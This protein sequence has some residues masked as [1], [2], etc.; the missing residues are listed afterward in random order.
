M[1]GSKLRNLEGLEQ[2]IEQEQVIFLWIVRD[3][4]HVA[5]DSEENI[6][7]LDISPQLSF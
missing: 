6:I 5:D 4:Y 7:Q 2:A 3:N 1:A